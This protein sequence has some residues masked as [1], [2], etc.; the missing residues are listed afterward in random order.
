MCTNAW[1]VVGAPNGALLPALE[2]LFSAGRWLQPLVAPVKSS[3]LPKGMS[4]E[5][6]TFRLRGS[7][8]S[9]DH[10]PGPFTMRNKTVSICAYSDRISCNTAQ[11]PACGGAGGRGQW[12]GSQ[13]QGNLRRKNCHNHFREKWDRNQPRGQPRKQQHPTNDLKTPDEG[14]REVGKRNSQFCE[15]A[16][17]LV[18]VDKFQ[19]PFPENTPP[20]MSLRIRMDL[21]PSVGGFISHEIISFIRVGFMLPLDLCERVPS[22]QKTSCSRRNRTT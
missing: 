5:T 12:R 1:S 16:N 19:Q 7:T 4:L 6:P 15:T 17:S 21:G 2:S 13:I 22:R 18:R 3:G 11:N 10:S 8:A 20:A 14:R 9:S